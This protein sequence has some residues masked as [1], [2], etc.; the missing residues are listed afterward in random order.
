MGKV[1][2]R[3]II[4]TTDSCFKVKLGSTTENKFLTREEKQVCNNQKLPGIFSRIILTA[5]QEKCACSTPTAKKIEKGV[6][7][8][9]RSHQPPLLLNLNIILTFFL[10][11]FL[12]A[13]N[14]YLHA[15]FF[16]LPVYYFS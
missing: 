4:Q 2:L 14:I 6:I 8:V 7:Y 13:L 9:Q 12:L 3:C 11:F 16:V 5:S 15:G 1:F 10:V